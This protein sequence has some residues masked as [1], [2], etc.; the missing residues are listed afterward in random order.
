MDFFGKAGSSV[1]SFFDDVSTEAE[2]VLETASVV[3]NSDA[4]LLNSDS[5]AQMDP[6][7]LRSRGC[8]GEIRAAEDT[9]LSQGG[10]RQCTGKSKQLRKK[11]VPAV[12]WQL[13]PS[14][15]LAV[16]SVCVSSHPT[17]E[18]SLEEAW[19]IFMNLRKHDQHMSR[20]YMRD[21]V[22][23]LVLQEGVGESKVDELFVIV[24]WATQ[25]QR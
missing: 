20:E 1:K 25:N 10:H 18:Q 15:S 22:S 13:I 6:R 3:F 19:A 4:D 24:C 17:R 21:Y 7:M 11:Q 2:E 5:K 9:L 16:P 12:Q 8:G 14:L 23:P